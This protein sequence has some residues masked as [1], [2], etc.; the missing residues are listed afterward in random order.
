MTTAQP[1]LRRIYTPST[2]ASMTK[3]ADWIARRRAWL[4]VV[5]GKGRG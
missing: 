3:L 5:I 4:A 1:E 2:Y